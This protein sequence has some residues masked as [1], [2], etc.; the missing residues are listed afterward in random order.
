MGAALGHINYITVLG[1][2]SMDLRDGEL[3]FECNLPYHGV[4]M[5]VEQLAAMA[6][7]TG[8][9]L[10]EYIP[11]LQRLCWTDETAE[12]ALGLAEAVEQGQAEGDAEAGQETQESLRAFLEALRD[13]P[14]SDSEDEP[15]EQDRSA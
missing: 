9:M 1:K 2:F 5:S 12:G 6:G 4:G 15:G 8:S 3:A 7:I 10:S 13:N 11:L 14:A